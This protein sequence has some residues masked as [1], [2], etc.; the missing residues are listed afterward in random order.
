LKL[1]VAIHNFNT[2]PNNCNA[3]DGANFA[4][5]EYVQLLNNNNQ[6]I[7]LEI[8]DFNRLCQDDSYAYRVLKDCDCVVSN[9]G[10][11][12]YIYFYLREKFRLNFRIV[13]DVR[14]ALWHSYLLQ[15]FL[16]S[17]YL[18]EQDTVI[19]SSA[20]S[21]DLFQ[22]LFPHTW[23]ESMIVCYPLMHF[24][25]AQRSDGRQKQSFSHSPLTIGVVG[26]LTPDKNFSQAIDL[27]IKLEKTDPGRFR[28]H[29]VGENLFSQYQLEFIQKRLKDEVGKPELYAWFPPVA[30]DQIW[31]EYSKIDI[32]FFPSTS[33]LETFGRVLVEASYWGLPV[34]SSSAA[35]ASELLPQESLLPTRY[36]TDQEFDT[37]R[38]HPL[39][40]VDLD[41]AIN[42]LT[43]RSTLPASSSYIDSYSNHDQLYFNILHEGNKIHQS[44]YIPTTE[45]QRQF[46]RSVS[47][48][49]LNEISNIVEADDVISELRHFL[50]TIQDF[51]SPT[52]YTAL[53]ELL[54]RS[55]YRAKTLNFIRRSINLHEDFTNIGG[56]DLQMAHI[57]KFY[58]HFNLSSQN[59]L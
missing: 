15:E 41:V 21:R 13:R 38:A 35:A 22:K 55:R 30:R 48:S 53:L 27:I 11:H 51:G 19:F 37:H 18:R 46:I 31:N 47:I 49:G 56:I 3:R 45:H 2:N 26:R 32:L 36:Y 39:G 54:I 20:Y 4:Y 43:D 40:Q 42:K 28:L 25:P 52:Y 8:H 7:Q 50:I 14:T 33:N 29:A 24:F 16:V 5:S 12:A 44:C 34:L 23:P 6:N 10:P 59:T 58:P 17:S 9:V 57:I 1:R